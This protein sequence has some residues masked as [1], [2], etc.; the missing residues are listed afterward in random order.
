MDQLGDCLVVRHYIL[1]EK[2]KITLKDSSDGELDECM[3][4]LYKGIFS[5]NFASQPG[6]LLFTTN[7]SING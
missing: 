2:A 3:K 7:R 6:K 5:L 4:H 1:L